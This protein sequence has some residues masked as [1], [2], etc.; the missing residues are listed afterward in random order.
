MWEFALAHYFLF[1]LLVYV[2]ILAIENV[3]V[4]FI[5][6][7][8]PNHFCTECEE[9]VAPDSSNPYIKVDQEDI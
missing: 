8:K 3:L 2:F 5:N 9:D 7:S 1:S 6:R 4:A